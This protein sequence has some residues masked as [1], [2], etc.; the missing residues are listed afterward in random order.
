VRLGSREGVDGGRKVRPGW[1][2]STFVVVLVQ[3]GNK[4]A[5]QYV[6]SPGDG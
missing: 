5:F 6:A 3:A 2:W 4:R 1:W